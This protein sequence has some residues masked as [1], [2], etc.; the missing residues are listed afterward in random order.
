MKRID[1]CVECGGILWP[2]G[3]SGLRLQTHRKCYD[4]ASTRDLVERCERRLI[5]DAKR[6]GATEYVFVD[7]ASIHGH[8]EQQGENMHI[9]VQREWPGAIHDPDKSNDKTWAFLIPAERPHNELEIPPG[10]RCGG[11]WRSIIRSLVRDELRK[12]LTTK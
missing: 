1:R 8:G 10:L 5:L 12:I 6:D 3:R 7:W 11:T 9:H 2:W 4:D